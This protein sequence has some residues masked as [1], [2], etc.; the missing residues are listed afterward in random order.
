MTL[1]EMGTISRAVWALG[2]FTFRPTPMAPQFGFD[3]AKLRPTT[4]RRL[5]LGGSSRFHRD[6]EN[7]PQWVLRQP[8]N[9]PNAR[10]YSLGR[11]RRS[12]ETAQYTPRFTCLIKAAVVPSK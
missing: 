7:A 3:S 12:G 9:R 2:L 1:G 8:L 11:I 10:C 4:W 6:R 5:Q